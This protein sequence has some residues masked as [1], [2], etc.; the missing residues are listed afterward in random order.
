MKLHSKSLDPRARMRRA[1]KREAMNIGKRLTYAREKIGYTR[2]YAA[3]EAQI[4]VEL[5]RTAEQREG[6]NLTWSQLVRLG[7]VYKRRADWFLEDG[8]PDDPH[9]VKGE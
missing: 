1:R 8:P 6:T 9:Q 3:A 5:L 7:D 4:N 2:E